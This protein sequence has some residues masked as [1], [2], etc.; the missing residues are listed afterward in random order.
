[1]VTLIKN[2]QVIAFR[3]GEHAVMPSGVVAF[4]RTEI[5]HVGETFSGHADEVIDASGMTDTPFTRGYWEDMGS[6]NAAANYEG[7][8]RILPTVR[9]AV[10]IED[11]LI[12]AECAFAELLLS[13]STTVVELGFD[14][15]MMQGGDISTTHRMAD[16]AAA[17]GVRAYFGPRYRS[18]YW[19]LDG[20]D[21]VQYHWYADRGRNRFDDCVAFCSEANGRHGDLIRTMLA[22]GQVDTCDPDLL[23]E[24]R[25]VADR[26]GVPIQLHAGQSPTEYRAIRKS[27]GLSTIGY[28]AA[29]GL[30]GPDFIIGHGMFL[31]ED[32]AVDRFPAE[33]LGA[34]VES[35]TTI[36]HLPWVKA[37]QGAAMR[38]F[39]KFV[40]AGVRMALGTDT[41][42]FDII[43]EM[44]CAA[45]VSRVMDDSPRLTSSAHI[46]RAAT[47][48]GADAL[49]R[50][51]L[52][53]LAA[54]A[55]ADIVLIDARQL[56]AVPMRDP[57][58]F[59]VFNATGADVSTVIVDGR[60][61]VANRAVLTVDV[62]A[63][64]ARLAE[65]AR[66]VSDRIG[67]RL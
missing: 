3:D 22:P 29:T 36:V 41:Y 63:A 38:S 67:K 24:T 15:E 25:R 13:G 19:S 58:G 60:T 59:I 17:T 10:S 44:R 32:G 65:A 23:R 53:R 47:I 12:A 40:R 9:G 26:I 34:L 51:D 57:I 11:E 33:E 6:P 62:P 8:Y 45:T 49:G 27:H 56:H 18:G 39:G 7:L 1:L 66:R 2:G 64:T 54:G 5:V 43:Q 52:G 30:L 42:P 61:V 55:K 28:L 46:F 21:Q 31:T 4:D 50:S 37:R 16:I 14:F 48:G 20:A 35:R